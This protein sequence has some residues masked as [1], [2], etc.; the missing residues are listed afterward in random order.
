MTRRIPIDRWK[1]RRAMA[2]LAFVAGIGYPGLLLAGFGRDL[3]DLALPFYTFVG[4]VVGAYIGFATFDDRWQ[5]APHGAG[6]APMEG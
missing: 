6:A 1:H 5:R 4:T 3:V 2:W